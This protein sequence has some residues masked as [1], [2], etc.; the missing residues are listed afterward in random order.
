MRSVLSLPLVV[1]GAA[2]CAEHRSQNPTGSPRSTS[3]PAP[4]LPPIHRWPWANA[5]MFWRTQTLAAQLEQALSTRG[6]IEQAKG[7]LVSQQGCSADEAFDILVRASQRTH[8]EL[9]DVA[10]GLVERAQAE[11][12]DR[13][14]KGSADGPF[15]GLRPVGT[16][17]EVCIAPHRL[18]EA[19]DASQWG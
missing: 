5:R 1:A 7:I 14:T 9:H 16:V 15:R 19:D 17:F 4:F 8:V 10:T 3:T 18:R 2:A 11:A 6:V 12:L 13:E